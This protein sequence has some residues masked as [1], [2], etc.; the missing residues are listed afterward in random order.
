MKVRDSLR[1]DW[2]V[3][4]LLLNPFVITAVDD[5]QKEL[6]QSTLNYSGFVDANCLI[7]IWPREMMNCRICLLSGNLKQPI[8]CCFYPSHVKDLDTLSDIII[9]SDG[10]HFT[11]L[12][13]A[14]AANSASFSVSP[15][16]KQSIP[17]D[18]S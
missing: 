15:S 6:L 9:H 10:S 17:V 5:F 2:F 18:M 4:C 16:L 13:P 1:S 12:K 14:A 8:F 7:Y 11:L 3:I